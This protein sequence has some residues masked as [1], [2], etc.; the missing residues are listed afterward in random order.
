MKV[1]DDRYESIMRDYRRG[2]LSYEDCVDFFRDDK[3]L[4]ERFVSEVGEHKAEANPELDFLSEHWGAE[5]ANNVGFAAAHY[6]PF[7]DSFDAFLTHCVACG[8]N[9]GGMLLSG[10]R[11]LFPKVWDAIPD[12]M[13]HDPFFCLIKVLRLCGVVMP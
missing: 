11:E 3:V 2:L 10:I 6:A 1:F 9:W 7:N 13:G 8:G 4:A 12:D 5:V